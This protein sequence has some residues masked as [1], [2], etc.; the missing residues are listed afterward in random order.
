MDDYYDRLAANPDPLD[1]PPENKRREN[2]A[3]RGG[4]TPAEHKARLRA[5]LDEQ[6]TYLSDLIAKLE[7][8]EDEADDGLDQDEQELLAFDDSPEG[9]RLH[10]Y[11]SHWT[12]SLLRTIEAIT[13]LKKRGD[14]DEP[15][16]REE[17]TA[18]STT[19]NDEAIEPDRRKL[20]VSLAEQRD[21]A[22]A[23]VAPVSSST[24]R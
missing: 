9:D 8:E 24:R 6:C 13:R 5:V 11:Q 12:R 19:R 3:L 15:D 18:E 4:P 22:E 14:G 10:R 23:S 2:R 1:D 7:A 20:Q 16:A 21:E 17:T